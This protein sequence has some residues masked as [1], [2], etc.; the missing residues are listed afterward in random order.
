MWGVN[1]SD[2]TNVE[3]FNEEGVC[4]SCV[5]GEGGV[6]EIPVGFPPD[7]VNFNVFVKLVFKIV[8]NQRLSC[9]LKCIF[10]E[11]HSFTAA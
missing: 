4:M 10:K 1:K 2:V 6:R 5:W 11:P 8:Q 7:P 3:G 9:I